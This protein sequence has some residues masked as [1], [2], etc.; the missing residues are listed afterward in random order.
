MRLK[1]AYSGRVQPT[2]FGRLLEPASCVLCNRIGR[3]NDEVFANFGVE[4]EYYGC[5]YMCQECCGEV[6][7]F[8]GYVSNERFEELEENCEAMAMLI[9]SLNAKVAYLK[10]LLDARI[11]LAGSSEP[12]SDEPSGLPVF[13]VEPDTAFIDS[14]L[15]EHEP[16]SN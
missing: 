12:S 11:D 1:D 3:T 7:S 6:A 4:L 16:V 15:N 5:V 8:I 14:V 13:E 10:G 9:T 2:E